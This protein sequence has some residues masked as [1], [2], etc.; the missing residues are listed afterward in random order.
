MLLSYICGGIGNQLFQYAMAYCLAKKFNSELI[1]DISSYQRDKKRNFRLDYFNIPYTKTNQNGAP[2]G[3]RW[4]VRQIRYALTKVGF[5]PEWQWVKENEGHLLEYDHLD[6]SKNICLQGYWQN[7]IYFEE[8]SDEIRHIFSLRKLDYSLVAKISDETNGANSVCVH[9]R[10]GDYFSNRALAAKYG[11]CTA[12]YY[13]RAIDSI[14]KQINTPSFFV[15]SDDLEWAKKNIDSKN[16]KIAFVAIDCTEHTD[17]YEF[18]LMQQCKHHIISNS[19]FSWW[20][21][22]L[23]TNDPNHIVIYPGIQKRKSPIYPKNWQCG[24]VSD[25]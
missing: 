22:W 12:S 2:F 24:E 14:E 11:V 18:H 6:F 9:I 25:I 16:H 17:L 13:N 19:T 21:A 23:S 1:L 8:N 4:S 10:R 5:Y 20:S 7:P 15:F 3:T